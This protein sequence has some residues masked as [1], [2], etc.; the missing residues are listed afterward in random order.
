MSRIP[1]H[2]YDIRV[3]PGQC[4]NFWRG[5][6]LILNSYG[7]CLRHLRDCSRFGKTNSSQICNLLGR[8]YVAKIRQSYFN[9]M[10]SSLW[11][12]TILDSVLILVSVLIFVTWYLDL[13]LPM[14]FF[15]T[16]KFQNQLKLPVDLYQETILVFC[17]TPISIRKVG[18]VKKYQIW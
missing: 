13:D 12:I 7:F 16:D 11:D 6:I 8:R 14:L 2:F 17:M 3:L 5:I 15:R 1:L 10:T 4:N 9:I 18:L